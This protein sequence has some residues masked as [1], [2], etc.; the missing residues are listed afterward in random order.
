MPARAY[1]LPLAQT[2]RDEHFDVVQINEDGRY[3]PNGRHGR[4]LRRRLGIETHHQHVVHTNTYV[5]TRV[6]TVI[7]R[8]NHTFQATPTTTHTVPN[9]V[10]AAVTKANLDLRLPTN[11]LC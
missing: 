6:P 1:I 9:T 4:V 8:G 5:A 10:V 2:F 7:S 11:M 3:G